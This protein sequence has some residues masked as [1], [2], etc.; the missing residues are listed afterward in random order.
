M[1][2]REQIINDLLN[3][4]KEHRNAI[5]DMIGDLEGLKKQ[6]DRLIPERVDARYGCVFEEKGKTLTGQLTT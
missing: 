5:M 2:Q 4:F 6:I 1:A 3:E